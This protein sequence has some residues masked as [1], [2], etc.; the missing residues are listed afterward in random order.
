MLQTSLDS[1]QAGAT[2]EQVSSSYR[3]TMQNA[4]Q[5]RSN[6]GDRTLNMH[7]YAHDSKSVARMLSENKHVLRSALNDANGE[8]GGRADG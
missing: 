3:Q 8:Y 1:L 5:Q 6:A 4:S 2:M 7:I